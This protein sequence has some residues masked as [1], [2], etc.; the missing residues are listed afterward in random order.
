V[1]LIHLAYRFELDPNDRQSTNQSVVSPS[2]STQ[3][4][5]ACTRNNSA[6]NRGNAHA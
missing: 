2:L 6:R 1:D 4:V 5:K 3:T